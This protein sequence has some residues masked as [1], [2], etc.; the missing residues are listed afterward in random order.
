VTR[1]EKSTSLASICAGPKRA[2]AASRFKPE[3]DIP[4][5]LSSSSS[6]SLYDEDEEFDR[7]VS[8]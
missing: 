7:I 6:K 4:L 3:R 2:R 8:V 5:L 1:S